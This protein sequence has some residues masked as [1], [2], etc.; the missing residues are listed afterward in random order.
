MK[1]ESKTNKCKQFL[2]LLYT[3]RLTFWGWGRHVPNFNWLRLKIFKFSC[4]LRKQ[5][6]T[7]FFLSTRKK[8]TLYNTKVQL[9][10]LKGCVSFCR[11]ELKLCNKISRTCYYRRRDNLQLCNKSS[12]SRFCLVCLKAYQHLIGY[13]MP[14]FNLPGSFGYFVFK[15]LLP[16][17]FLFLFQ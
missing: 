7:A 9:M 4:A 6:L 12:G 3:K 1:D 5:I 8:K 13:L 15:Y 16:L 10:F 14:K 11:E 17:I 2:V